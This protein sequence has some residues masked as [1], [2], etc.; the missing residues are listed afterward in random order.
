M[1]LQNLTIGLLALTG[2]AAAAPQGAGSAADEAAKDFSEEPE[3]PA[4]TAEE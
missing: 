4:T 2:T 3:S 1:R